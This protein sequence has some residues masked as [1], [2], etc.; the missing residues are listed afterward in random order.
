VV[1]M[2]EL[3]ERLECLSCGNTEQIGYQHG[4]EPD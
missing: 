2:P 3:H 1:G 4:D